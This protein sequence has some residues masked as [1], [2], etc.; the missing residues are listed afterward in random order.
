[1]NRGDT[2][3]PERFMD[4]SNDF[5]LTCALQKLVELRLREKLQVL[6]RFL[7]LGFKQGLLSSELR[8]VSPALEQP[9]LQS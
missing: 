5:L 3:F 4:R 6:I 9:P 8:V 1:M 7:L 2:V